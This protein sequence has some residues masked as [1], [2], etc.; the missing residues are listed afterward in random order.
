MNPRAGRDA[1]GQ[2]KNLALSGIKPR[3][4]SSSIWSLSYSVHVPVEAEI[5]REETLGNLGIYGII[6]E[7]I[8][9]K[10]G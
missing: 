9:K 4:F 3:T 5:L 6:L 7:R 10:N 2:T 1:S 8:L